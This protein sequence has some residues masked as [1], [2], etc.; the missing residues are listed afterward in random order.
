MCP[1]RESIDTHAELKPEWSGDFFDALDDLFDASRKHRL[2]SMPSTASKASTG[3]VGRAEG[4]LAADTK[5]R[6]LGL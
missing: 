3:R 6:I 4:E 2:L 1:A 5:V